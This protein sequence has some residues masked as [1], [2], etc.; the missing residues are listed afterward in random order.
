MDLHRLGMKGLN[1]SVGVVL[2][3]ESARLRVWR[4]GSENYYPPWLAVLGTPRY[5]D[6]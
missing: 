5:R 4:R 3:I 2:I 1:W 6:L